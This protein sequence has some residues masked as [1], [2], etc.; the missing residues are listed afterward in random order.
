MNLFSLEGKKAIV[1]GASRGIGK[2]I[3]IGM[4]QVGADVVCVSSK[5]GGAM[6]TVRKIQSLKRNATH[7]TADLSKR[8]DQDRLIKDGIDFLGGLDILVNN[9]GMIHR[10]AAIDFSDEGWDKVLE[11]NLSAVFRLA[12][13]AAQVMAVQKSGKIINTASL[14]S[15]FG[16]ITVASYAAAKHGVAGLTKALS[17]EWASLGIQ[18]NSIAPGYIRTDVTQ[19]LQ[20]D[21]ERF[22]MILSRIPAGR[23]GVPEDLVGAAIFLASKASDYVTGSL[24]TVD[25]GWT[26]R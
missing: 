24:V 5:D 12:R 6:D 18:I 17:N 11:V 25:G 15:Y 8:E 4:A 16:G 1:T 21:P 20:D 19:A 7:I 9:A 2:A 14:L 23:W 13:S 26:G 22:N 3:A 10:Q